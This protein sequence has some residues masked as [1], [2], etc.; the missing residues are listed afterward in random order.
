MDNIEIVKRLTKV[1]SEEIHVSD[2][3]FL[4]T[5][6]V[7]RNGE[8]IFKF[9]KHPDV[10][11]ENEIRLLDFLNSENLNVN[12]QRV[13]WISPD[14]SYVG[15]YGVKGKAAEHLSLS[16]EEKLSVG[17]QLGVFLKK[18][19]SLSPDRTGSFSV[20][21]EI[22]AWQERFLK[23]AKI[24]TEYFTSEEMEKLHSFVFE[25]APKELTALGEKQ[26]F[27]HADL[28]EGNIFLD[29][30]GKVG[31]ID[32]NESAYAD[33]AAD[34]MDIE[35]DSICNALLEAY[36]ADD[37]LREKVKIRRLIRP[38]FV[39]ET[40]SQRGQKAVEKYIDRIRQTLL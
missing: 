36:G 15:L 32:F 30:N 35:D 19:H 37:T 6:Y 33:E 12:L 16:D 21:E 4:S 22:S 3:G 23:S 38:L 29:D 7:I 10:S 17:R 14:D 24:M 5:G 1:N 31:V 20:E 28:G 40:Y 13:G 8:I 11:Y 18:L 2:D 25:K 26:V 27:S 9:K 34:F 39:I